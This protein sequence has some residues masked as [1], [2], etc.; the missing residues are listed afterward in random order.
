[1]DDDPLAQHVAPEPSDSRAV[2]RRTRSAGDAAGCASF[3]ER[4]ATPP[5]YRPLRRRGLEGAPQDDRRRG[6]HA[7]CRVPTPPSAPTSRNHHLA[8]DP[9]LRDH[10]AGRSS[11]TTTLR[12]VRCARG[13]ARRRRW[14]GVPDDED[15]GVA[16][17]AAP[18]GASTTA[19]R[20]TIRTPRRSTT[21]RSRRRAS[22]NAP[23]RRG[24]VDGASAGGQP[25]R[26]DVAPRATK[27]S[28]CPPPSCSS[29]RGRPHREQGHLRATGASTRDRPGVSP[30]L[31]ALCARATT[32][33]TRTYPCSVT[34]PASR[35]S[36]SR[37]AETCCPAGAV[38]PPSPRRRRRPP[39]PRAGR[40]C[41]RRV[42]GAPGRRG[43]RRGPPVRRR[44]RRGVRPALQTDHS[45]R[46]ADF[47]D[48]V[49]GDDDAA[50]PRPGPLIGWARELARPRRRC[51]SRPARRRDRRVRGD[52]RG[53]R[54]RRRGQL[55]VA[56]RI[57]T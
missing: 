45:W 55:A 39:S 40:R 46:G 25:R 50:P 37:A 36:G 13:C 27:D 29:A 43:H 49:A 8:A 1:M 51:R 9:C 35:G 17:R 34:S 10:T 12:S 24:V 54:H 6:H 56:W 15:V 26:S 38:A 5:A 57:D 28:R 19:C 16:R 23:R 11:P 47:A 20:Q 48:H 53:G 30:D 22:S 18:R 21:P 14:R 3:A 41:P 32:S 42:G 33:R 44:P 31:V 52:R 7:V 4:L 2:G